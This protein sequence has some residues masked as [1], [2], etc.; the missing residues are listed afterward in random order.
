MRVVLQILTLVLCISTSLQAQFLKKLQQRVQEEV[1]DKVA[2]KL[3]DELADDIAN[4]IYKPLDQA[5]ADAYTESLNDST[6]QSSGGSSSFLLNFE[7]AAE[8][9]PTSY[10]FD[11]INHMEIEDEKGEINMMKMM[12]PKEGEY[13]G[14][15][16]IDD[17]NS[18]MMV[19]DMQNEIIAMYSEEKG[20]KKVTV[21]PS[22]TDFAS[23]YLKNSG[24][25]EDEYTFE[26]TGKTKTIL[27]YNC[28]EYKVESE[29]YITYSFATNDFPISWK[30]SYGKYIAKFAPAAASDMEGLQNAMTLYS[31]TTYKNN[32]NKS[33]YAEVVKV[34]QSGLLLT[35]ADFEKVKFGEE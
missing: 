17:G 15:E 4:K 12:F 14:M 20:K 19:Y 18:I 25:I 1:I 10:T 6:A 31:K 7:K 2:D 23:A 16:T 8:K 32:K 21:M 34:D 22:M 35:N 13:F 33:S 3:A 24:Q 26:K 29:K 27:G 11:V 28:E 30:D 5:F 9:L